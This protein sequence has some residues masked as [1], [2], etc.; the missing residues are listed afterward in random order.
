MKVDLFEEEIFVFTPKGD[1]I[2]LPIGATALDFAFSVHTKIGITTVGAKVNGRMVPLKKTLKSG[3]I[4]EILTSPNQK[5]GKD[6][7]NFVTTSKARNKIRSHLRSEQR[8]R[9]RVVGQALPFDGRELF[10]ADGRVVHV[11]LGH[12][13]HRHRFSE[14]RI[15]ALQV[16]RRDDDTHR[17]LPL[18]RIGF[19]FGDPGLDHPVRQCHRP[20][21]QG[22]GNAQED[23]VFV[24]LD[25]HACSS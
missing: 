25:G 9:S 16:A 8:D 1:V 13:A 19:E 2:Q 23:P 15:A 21:S 7:L 11:L 17:L 6:W 10:R 18:L 12:L 22:N 14:Q 5:P 20:Q 4:I 3:D 24:Q